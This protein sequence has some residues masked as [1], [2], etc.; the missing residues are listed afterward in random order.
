MR[1]RLEAQFSVPLA[2]KRRLAGGADEKEEMR[3]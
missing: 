1:L 3:E 2:P